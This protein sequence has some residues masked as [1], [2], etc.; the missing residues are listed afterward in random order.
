MFAELTWISWLKFGAAVCLFVGP[1]FGLLSFYP[2][3][4]Q[5]DRTQMAA[6]ITALVISFWAIALAW[7]GLAG[8]A[9]T[10]VAVGV[11]LAAGWAFRPGALPFMVSSQPTGRGH[12][13]D[14]SRIPMSIGI[15]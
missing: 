6:L 4:R 15:R 10:P 13:P 1:G 12:V 7:L 14:A 2:G 5:F 11:I 9:L 8:I 3:R